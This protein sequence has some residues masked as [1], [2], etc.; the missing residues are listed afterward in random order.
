MAS[1]TV[2]STQMLVVQPVTSRYF[3]SSPSSTSSSSVSK[4]PL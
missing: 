1:R 2:D 4:K 3:A